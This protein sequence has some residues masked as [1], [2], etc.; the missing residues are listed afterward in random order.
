MV[1]RLIT[2]DFLCLDRDENDETPVKAGVFLF[3]QF[4]GKG[5]VNCVN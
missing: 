3:G 5:L 2:I 1:N 4:Q